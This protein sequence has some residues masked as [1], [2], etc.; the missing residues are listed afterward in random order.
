MMFF[1]ALEGERGRHMSMKPAC[2][3]GALHRRGHRFPES[4]GI[5]WMFVG[6]AWTYPTNIQ[7]HI[8][9]LGAVILRPAPPISGLRGKEALPPHV[10]MF[11]E[12]Y[13]ESRR[14]Y[15][16]I[17]ADSYSRHT[18]FTVSGSCR[19]SSTISASELSLQITSEMTR[20]V[21]SDK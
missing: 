9:R 3:E 6:S 12:H 7:Y 8:Q 10:C 1:P 5:K 14:N 11:R 16:K 17:A 13:C 2:V 20:L 19:G 4:V 21:T 18:E 15:R